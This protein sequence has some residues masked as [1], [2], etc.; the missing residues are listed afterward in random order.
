[1]TYLHPHPSPRAVSDIDSALAVF[2]GFRPRLLNIAFRVV[3]SATEAEDIV[4]EAWVRWQLTDRTVVR[5]PE[6]FLTTA[7]ARLA[8]NLVDSARFRR[9]TC[10]G[11]G[12]H[13]PVDTGPDPSTQAEQVVEAQ[14]AMHL[15]RTSLTP[16]QCRAYVLREAFQFPYA[17]I[18]S[19]LGTTEANA[20]QLV[21]RARQHVAT[22][23]SGTDAAHTG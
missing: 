18:G 17:E 8:L 15:L 20:R 6:A 14:Q 22:H 2:A 9:E 23:T 12:V 16:A 19:M 1:M 4:Q 21:R 3:G 10:P 11:A 5:Q 13:E 7:T